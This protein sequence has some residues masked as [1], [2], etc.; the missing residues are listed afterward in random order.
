MFDH[1]ELSFELAPH[2][3][4]HEIGLVQDDPLL[5]C[6][7]VLHLL[8]FLLEHLRFDRLQDLPL[9]QLEES[10][11]LIKLLLFLFIEEG[12]II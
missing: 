10:V 3:I 8:D 1:K 11:F 4:D 2:P 7:D 6:A 5:H 9:V 12:H